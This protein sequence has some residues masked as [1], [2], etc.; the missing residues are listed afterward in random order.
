[1]Q[2]FVQRRRKE[3]GRKKEEKKKFDQATL[4][5]VNRMMIEVMITKGARK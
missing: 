1:M 2:C 3:G 4:L 5:T